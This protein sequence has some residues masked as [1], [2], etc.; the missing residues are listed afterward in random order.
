MAKV[1]LSKET[2]CWEWQ[3]A[4]SSGYSSISVNGKCKRGHRVTYEIFVEAIPDGLQIDHLCC[5]RGCVNPRHL[6]PVTAHQNSSARIH[7]RKAGVMPVIGRAPIEPAKAWH[8]D[9]NF[10]HLDRAIDAGLIL[11]SDPDMLRL[12]ETLFKDLSRWSRRVKHDY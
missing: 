1:V 7:M 12:N 11:R 5:N 2:G 4:K 3:G 10:A 9:L 8:K 6:E